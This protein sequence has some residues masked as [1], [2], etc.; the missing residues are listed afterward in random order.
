MKKT[1][2]SMI[3]VLTVLVMLFAGVGCNMFT[4]QTPENTTDVAEQTE[5]P[6]ETEAIDFN[7][8][9]ETEKLTGVWQVTVDLKDV[10]AGEDDT[11]EYTSYFEDIDSEVAMTM[12]LNADGTYAIEMDMEGV[13]EVVRTA[14]TKY[15]EGQFDLGSLGMTLDDALALAGTSMDAL[16]DEAMEAFDKSS[17]GELDASGVWKAED[18]KIYLAEAGEEFDE[19]YET[20]EVTETELTLLSSTEASDDSL[21][22]Y[23]MTFTRVG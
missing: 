8:M 22:E 20:Y 1:V 5:K 19:D 6:A 2:L 13:K 18:G 9:T 14:L 17:A 4:A 11:A 23:P 21:F 16:L 10:L 12:N 3:A 7:S 15:A